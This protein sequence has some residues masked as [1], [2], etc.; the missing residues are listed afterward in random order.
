[1]QSFHTVPI[2]SP[3]LNVSGPTVSGTVDYNTNVMPTTA[4]AE[5]LNETYFIL[6]QFTR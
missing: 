1:M 5:L 4:A 6:L 3:L 2:I